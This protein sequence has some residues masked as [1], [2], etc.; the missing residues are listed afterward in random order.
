MTT[1]IYQHTCLYS[2]V[3]NYYTR[4]GW[5]VTITLPRAGFAIIA[6]LI[7]RNLITKLDLVRFMHISGW[8]WLY[9]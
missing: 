1:R 9:D 2:R 7:Q 3:F 5:I 4:Y 6:Q 8:L